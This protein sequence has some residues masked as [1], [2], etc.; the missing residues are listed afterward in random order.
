VVG[1]SLCGAVFGVLFVLNE[2]ALQCGV[3]RAL[4][5]SRLVLRCDPAT[6]RK[7]R[8]RREDKLQRLAERNAF[9]AQS[10]RAYPEAGLRGLTP[11]G[12]CERIEKA[13]PTLTTSRAESRHSDRWWL[14]WPDARI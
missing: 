3:Q 8:H 9:E 1:E 7:E 10:Q 2:L 6:Q 11:Q 13:P 5:R 14:L 4:G 12:P